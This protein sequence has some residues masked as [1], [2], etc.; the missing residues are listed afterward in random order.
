[1]F[2]V[3]LNYK[4][5]KDMAHFIFFILFS[6]PLLI[7]KPVESVTVSFIS[8]VFPESVFQII[9]YFMCL[10]L[11]FLFHFFLRAPITCLITIVSLL[12][13]SNTY[14]PN[15]GEELVSSGNWSISGERKE[16]TKSCQLLNLSVLIADKLCRWSLFGIFDGSRVMKDTVETKWFW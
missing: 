4:R 3:P 8:F 9:R 7:Y 12:L 11:L 2:Y 13:I 10:M 5:S 6:M 16:I 15:G 14:V 1:M